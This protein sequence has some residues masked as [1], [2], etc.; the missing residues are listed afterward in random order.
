MKQ[1]ISS[2]ETSQRQVAKVHTKLIENGTYQKDVTILDWGGGK[3]DDAKVHA[4]KT[5]C[6]FRIYDP[7]NRTKDY[8][9]YTLSKGKVDILVLANVLNVIKEKDARLATMRKAKKYL[10]KGGKVYVSIYNAK[11]SKDYVHGEGQLTTRGWQ[12]CQP[13]NYYKEEVL[14]VFNNNET[15]IL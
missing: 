13:K 7:Y 10:K 14:S 3:Y 1:K 4:M 5:G 15:V 9:D 8:N 12:N 6:E 2:K 11:K